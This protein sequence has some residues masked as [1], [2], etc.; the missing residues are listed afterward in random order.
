MIV[1]ETRSINAPT[2]NGDL[3]R[4]TFRSHI[5]NFIYSSRLVDVENEEQAEAIANQMQDA[6]S[7]AIITMTR[8]SFYF[9]PMTGGDL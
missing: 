8:I 6:N 4:Y 9:G 2:P 5:G 7:E 3:I 1:R